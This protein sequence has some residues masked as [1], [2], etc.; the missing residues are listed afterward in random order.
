MILR[1][2]KKR[3]S[4]SSSIGISVLKTN[5]HELFDLWEAVHYTYNMNQHIEKLTETLPLAPQ[6]ATLS[7]LLQDAKNNSEITEQLHQAL[8]YYKEYW[9]NN[10]QTSTHA[11]WDNS[12]SFLPTRGGI[13]TSLKLHGKEIFYNDMERVL[14]LNTSLRGSFWMTPY[15][16]PQEKNEYNPYG[17][18]HGYGRNIERR[19]SVIPGT[20]TANIDELV[21]QNIEPNAVISGLELS[22]SCVFG[23]WSEPQKAYLSLTMQNTSTQPLPYSPGHHTYY[24][25][26]HEDQETFSLEGTPFTNEQLRTFMKTWKWPQGENPIKMKNTWHPLILTIPSIGKLRLRFQKPFTDIWIWCEPGKPFLCIE[27][28]MRAWSKQAVGTILPWETKTCSFSIE[29]LEA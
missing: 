22:Q 8:A 10:D 18:Q 12:V 9:L 17:L 26:P 2:Y 28:T 13:I 6:T 14:D 11:Q 7:W 16:W 15:A 29:L 4:H 19:P 21:D 1:R 27:P 5:N 20:L 3:V 25:L 23:T 24:A